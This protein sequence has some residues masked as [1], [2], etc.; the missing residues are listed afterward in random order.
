[1]DFCITNN[2]LKYN[3]SYVESGAMKR[4]IISIWQK[5]ISY[6]HMGLSND[7]TGVEFINSYYKVGGIRQSS[8]DHLIDDRRPLAFEHIHCA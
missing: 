4:L 6:Y 1:M 3:I 5:Y 2:N 7:T 8:Y